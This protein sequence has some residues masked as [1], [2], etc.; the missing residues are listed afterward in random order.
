MRKFLWDDPS[1]PSVS[2]YILLE[3]G[4]RRKRRSWWLSWLTDTVRVRVLFDWERL[5]AALDEGP[6]CTLWTSFG[7]VHYPSWALAV[8]GGLLFL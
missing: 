5:G 1:S 6:F 7:L 8:G 2:S 4:E 3:R